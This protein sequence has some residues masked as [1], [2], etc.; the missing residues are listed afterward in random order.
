MAGTTARACLY[1]VLGGWFALTVGQQFKKRP[2]VLNKVDPG[3]VVLPVSTF[4]AP[5][6]GTTDAHL[7][8][9]HELADGGRT[10]WAEVPISR[11]R[12]LRD[13]LWHPHRRREKVLFDVQNDLTVLAGRPD[14]REYIH[15]TVPY[16]SLLN[17]VS[18]QQEA[19]ADARRVQ[20]MLVASGGNDHS[21]EP[22]TDFVSD[23][24]DLPTEGS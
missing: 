15:L 10:H 1:G 2:R 21:D 17:F 3:N 9:R 4:F 24:H 13:M 8:V 16:L 7:L 11:R 18:H 6:P 14:D 22:R 23:F 12:T 5:Q 20:F 19:P